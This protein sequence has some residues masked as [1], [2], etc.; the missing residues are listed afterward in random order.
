MLMRNHLFFIPLFIITFGHSQ[1]ISVIDVDTRL[2]IADVAVFN[3]SQEKFATTNVRGQVDISQFGSEE[4]IIFDHISHV[5]QEFVKS[6]IEHAGNVVYLKA[7]TRLLDEVVLSATKWKQRKEEVS[8]QVVS[9]NR[10]DVQ[11]ANPQTA[12]DLLS[13]SGKVFVQKS[14]QGGG[15][16]MIRGFSANRLLISVDGVRMNTA[17][18]RSGNL[19]NVISIDPFSVSSTEVI[20]GPGSTIYGSDAVGGAMSFFTLRPTLSAD[21]KPIFN[22]NA[23]IRHATANNEKTAHADFSLGFNKWAF[24][25][26]ITFSDFDDLVMGSHGPDEYLRPEYV[27]TEGGVDR[28][29]ENDDPKVQRPTGYDQANF[30]QKIEFVPNDRWNFGFGLY[31]TET[32]DYPRYDRLIRH[33]DGLPRSAEWFYG[34]Q[35]WLMT[36]LRVENRKSNDWY[37]KLRLTTALQYFEESRNDRDFQADIRTSREEQVD[38]YS[39]NLDLEK[40]L[41]PTSKLYYGAEYVLNNVFSKGEDISIIDN[42][43]QPTSTRYPDGSDWQSMAVYANYLYKPVRNLSLQGGLRYNYVLA[44]ADFDENNAFFNLP[45]E[46]AKVSTGALTGSFG[47]NWSPNQAI[48][49]KLNFSTAF[50]AP[51]IDDIGKIFDSEPG[52]VIVPNPDLRPEY[53]YNGEVGVGLNFEK[54]KI[55]LATYYTF[56]D[57]ALVRRSFTLNGEREILYDGELSNV[58]AIQNAAKARV[59]G[60]EAGVN[61]TL[62]HRLKLASKVSYTGGDEEQE[63]GTNASLRHAPPIFGDTHLIWDNHRLKLDLF[64]NY[65][66]EIT[67]D[68]LAPSEQNKPFLYALDQNGDPYSPSWYTLNIRGQYNFA[69]RLTT[70]IAIENI[71]DQRYRTYSSGIASAGRNFIASLKY[72]F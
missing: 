2:P 70:T 22:G 48:Q 54:V 69:N 5:Q 52:A 11:F 66:G 63:D 45:F 37:D 46:Q 17:I 43:T 21:G 27:V 12:A 18:F 59:Y 60:F 32:T 55:E 29:V 36:N 14:Q 7:E 58:F 30:M 56:L 19:Q 40:K 8:H 28:I 72:S 51:N 15:S 38:A 64:A 68:Q 57:D 67:F 16:P 33:Q 4:Q 61:A 53:A 10:A 47:L 65:N 71:T 24:V 31:Y 35:R 49:W 26:S 34:P 1:K 42:T 6:D 44:N 41:S 50:R 23:F 25:S 9:I 13:S 62:S 20:L 39:A 3:R